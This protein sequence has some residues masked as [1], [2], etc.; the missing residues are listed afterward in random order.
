[1]EAGNFAPEYGYFPIGAGVHHAAHAFN[2]LADVA[3]RGPAFRTLKGKMF[4]EVGQAS[5]FIGF[6]TGTGSHADGNGNRRG[7]GHGG[8]QD[9]QLVTQDGA[10]KHLHLDLIGPFQGTRKHQK[11]PL[12]SGS[13]S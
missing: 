8:G 1:M 2:S 4:Q 7:V 3:G 11:N 13:S 9:P 10:L 12:T 5:L 6:I